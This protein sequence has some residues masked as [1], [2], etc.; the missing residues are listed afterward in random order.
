MDILIT[1]DAASVEPLHRQLYEELRKSIL[2]GR[3]SPGQRLP[4]TRAFAQ[5]LRLSRAT[6]TLSFSQLIGE[7]YLEARIG[8]GTF[9]SQQIPDE[10]TRAQPPDAAERASPAPPRMSAYGASLVNAAALE[11]RV[12]RA[13]VNFRDGRP[14]FDHFP[15]ATW[16]KLLARHCR[17][18]AEILDY[19]PE[20]AG[21]RPLREAI[22][23]YL[24]RSRAV[25]CSA[26]NIVIVSGSQQG[27]D[28]T[29]RVIVDRGDLV[30]VE[31]PGYPGAQR[32][33]VAQGAKLVGIPVDAEGLLVERLFA[34][35]PRTIKLVYL[36]PS[37][38]FPTG[39][40]LP[41]RR[42]LELLRWAHRTGAVILEDDYDSAYRYGERPIPALQGLDEGGSVVYIGTFSK[43]LFP[44]LRLGYVVVPDALVELLARAKAYSDRQSPLLEQ[45]A[46]A[47]FI[48]EGHFE[49]HL[50]RMRA[51]YDRRR[52]ALV[53][54]LTEHFGA[55]VSI[56]GERAGMHVLARFDTPFDNE[57]VVRRAARAGVFIASAEPLYLHEGGHGEF[58]LGFA[59]L[60]ERRIDDGIRRFAGA[61]R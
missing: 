45:H 37:H 9:V 24:T 60:D 20:P 23:R 39:A 57:E 28:L 15:V 36:T 6:V 4:S 8:S 51:L 30:A 43:V 52:T 46:L 56:S 40:V 44:A 19:T 53:R 35:G 49:R 48:E 47:D 38:Q 12:P 59:E 54:A 26:A 22:A 21:Y 58:V 17:A 27:I 50:R 41:L 11:P 31:N 7:G 13:S 61:L 34:Y 33:F 2:A 32:N 14:A 1:V 42:R 10:L 16:R 25:R 18:N 29:A 3:L 55:A 5:S